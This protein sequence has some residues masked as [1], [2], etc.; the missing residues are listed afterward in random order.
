MLWCIAAY[1]TWL[2]L[3]WA[4]L[5]GVWVGDAATCRLAE[6]GACW[7]FVADRLDFVLFG[8]YPA[9]EQWRAAIFL[10]AF[11]AMLAVT[12]FKL[13]P[14]RVLLLL[15]PVVIIAGFGIAL[16][17]SAPDTWGGL[18]LSVFL[19]IVV[20]VAAMPLAV[21]LGAGR[22][23]G[24]NALQGFLAA[25]VEVVRGLPLLVTLFVMTLVVPLL[26]P[27]ARTTAPIYLVAIGL[28]LYYVCIAGEVFRGVF[29][30]M[31]KGQ[32]EAAHALGL[33]WAKTFALIIVPQ[34]A[35]RSMPNL[36]SI[37]IMLFKDTSL[38]LVVGVYEFIGMSK[39]SVNDPQWIGFFLELF[40]FV[41]IVYVVICSLVSRIGSLAEK[42]QAS[43]SR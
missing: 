29:D 2:L 4:V 38:V 22:S 10:G 18:M 27:G 11:V 21:L 35:V 15:W 7:A 32:W 26:V 43:W 23:Y 9:E 13:L 28:T 25:L 1:L 14:P 8:G 37:W 39:L 31:P 5:R 20:A 33:G 24:P 40:I 41:S 19:T 36:V 30:T 17:G 6:S 16:Q 42:A 12:P 3:D 34:V